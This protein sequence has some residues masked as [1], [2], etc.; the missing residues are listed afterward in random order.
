MQSTSKGLSKTLS[1]FRKSFVVGPTRDLSLQKIPVFTKEEE[2][3]KVPRLNS[4][5]VLAFLG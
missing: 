2:D 4:L 5:T 1:K 3:R